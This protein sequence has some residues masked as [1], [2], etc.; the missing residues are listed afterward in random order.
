[1]TKSYTQRFVS[2]IK[3]EEEPSWRQSISHFFF[4]TYLNIL[5]VFVPLSIAAHHLDWDAALRFS[6]SFLAIVPLAKVCP[7][8]VVASPFSALTQPQLLGECTEQM[9]F[10]LG[11]TLAG[12]LNASFGNAV[13]IIVGIAA[14]LQGAL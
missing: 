12:L 10:S 14:L 4:G 7:T 11:D 5:L 13:E 6:F 9:S 8:R 3:A 1:M 2:L